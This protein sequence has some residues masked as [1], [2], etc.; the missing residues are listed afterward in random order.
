MATE[1]EDPKEVDVGMAVTEMS[2][3]GPCWERFERLIKD[4]KKM[5]QSAFKEIW[6]PFPEIV[7]LK[8]SSPFAFQ[9]A[10]DA[11]QAKR[12]QR[13]VTILSDISTFLAAGSKKVMDED[14]W[15]TLSRSSDPMDLQILH[16]LGESDRL[17]KSYRL[18]LLWTILPTSGWYYKRCFFGEPDPEMDSTNWSQVLQSVEQKNGLMIPPK[19]WK[20]AAIILGRFRSWCHGC[21]KKDVS[22]KQCS[23]C[24]MAHYCRYFDSQATS[25]A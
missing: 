6:R 23:S 24:S 25:T 18:I 19:D 9:D 10:L 4:P 14:D 20:Q 3:Y 7:W 8:F 12:E 21:S 1:Q 5:T 2:Q 11:L 17:N 16:G 15:M 13:G 22:L